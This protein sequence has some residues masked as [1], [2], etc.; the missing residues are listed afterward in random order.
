ML[1][2]LAISATI[3]AQ[4]AKPQAITPEQLMFFES[5]IRPIL[6]D[7]CYGCHSAQSGRSRGGYLIDT[8]DA[9]RRG[10]GSGPGIVPGK[11][12]ESLLI[13]AIRYHDEDLQM[14]PRAS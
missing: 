4:A 8:R 9:A 12:D 14:P 13:Q 7:Q 11:P 10:G 2:P 5:T 1:L 3:F 6:V